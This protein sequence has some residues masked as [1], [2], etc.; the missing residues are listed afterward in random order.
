MNKDLPDQVSVILA[1][2]IEF[3]KKH[4]AQFY[5][6]KEDNLLNNRNLILEGMNPALVA[7]VNTVPLANHQEHTE[8]IEA[9]I[10]AILS[11]KNLNTDHK[12][13]SKDMVENMK[14]EVYKYRKRFGLG[15][16]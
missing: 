1:K 12:Q 11:D 7:Y 4:L 8:D 13:P 2:S 9:L 15:E 14:I 10:V 3:G 5:V 6:F 16:K